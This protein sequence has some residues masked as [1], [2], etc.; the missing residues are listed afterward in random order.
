MK[1]CYLEGRRFIC[2]IGWIVGVSLDFLPLGR[3]YARSDLV[4]VFLLFCGLIPDPMAMGSFSGWGFFQ[5]QP[6]G[7]QDACPTK[8]ER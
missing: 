1:R 5:P 6:L 7:R 4:G 3:I 2:W 8:A